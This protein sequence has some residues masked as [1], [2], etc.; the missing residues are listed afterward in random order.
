MT[1]LVSRLNS[2]QE[3]AREKLQQAKIRA[4]KYYD[5][6]AHPVEFKTGDYAYLLSGPKPGKFDDQYSRRYLI[7][8]TWENGNVR[9][10]IAKNKSK[11]VHGNR[12]RIAKLQIEE[13]EC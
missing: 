2:I 11:I 7:I 5:M 3:I 6:R 1:E 8:E 13:N 4:K 9:I 10:K 12:L